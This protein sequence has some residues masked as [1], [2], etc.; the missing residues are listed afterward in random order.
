MSKINRQVRPVEA[1]LT[2]TKDYRTSKRSLSREAKGR[3]YWHTHTRIRRSTS[4][5]IVNFHLANKSS[6]NDFAFIFCKSFS[7]ISRWRVSINDTSQI[8]FHLCAFNF[9]MSVHT[10]LR[11]RINHIKDQTI[12][13]QHLTFSSP[14]AFEF[15]SKKEIRPDSQRTVRTR[16]LFEL[17]WCV[18]WVFI[19]QTRHEWHKSRRNRNLLN[20]NEEE[21]TKF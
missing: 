19:C 4:K 7:L 14:C 15:V 17:L 8:L 13:S 10:S 5:L 21:E 18:Q 3:K 2:T 11:I 9:C 1:T 20:N 12:V 16:A 6:S